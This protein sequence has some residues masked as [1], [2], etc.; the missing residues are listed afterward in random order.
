[1]T[2]GTATA[3]V[4]AS[5]MTNGT[6]SNSKMTN[7]TVTGQGGGSSLTLQYKDGASTGT[8]TLAIPDGIPIVTLEPGAVADLQPGTHVFVVAHQNADHALTADR[9]MAGKN[10]IV[11]PM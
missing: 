8:Q 2:N 9:V 3:T 7:G 5:R 10:G 6:V 4:P 1:M 11:P